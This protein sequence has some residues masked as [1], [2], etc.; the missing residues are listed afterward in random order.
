MKFHVLSSLL[1]RIPFSLTFWTWK[2]RQDLGPGLGQLTPPP[3]TPN[4]HGLDG[5]PN[6]FFSKS[7]KVISPMRINICLLFGVDIPTTIFC[8]LCPLVQLSRLSEAATRCFEKVFIS[9]VREGRVFIRASLFCLLQT[10]PH[11]LPIIKF[12]K[13]GKALE[14]PSCSPPNH[15]KQSNFTQ[16]TTVQPI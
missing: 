7:L 1:T 12:E 15:P 4:S 3:G 6:P 2:V 8:C 10:L 5:W 9:H 16:N 13:W 11:F 14:K